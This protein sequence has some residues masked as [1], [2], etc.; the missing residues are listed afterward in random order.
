MR[1]FIAIQLVIILIIIGLLPIHA[2][3]ET[4]NRLEMNVE[5]GFNGKAKQNSGF[6]VS[7]TITN[8][9]E[10]F[11][12]DLVVTVP[13][14]YQSI[15]NIVMPIDIATGSTKEINFSIPSFVMESY[16]GA[17]NQRM[18]FFHL[19]EG[20]WKKGKKVK[21]DSS[22]KLQPRYFADNQSVI[23]IVS[24]N[25]DALN[26]L[27][28][29]S[30]SGTNK[31]VISLKNKNIPDEALGLQAIDMLVVND[32][33]FSSLPEKKQLAVKEWVAQ[34]G[35]LITGSTPGL[36]KKMGL[37]ADILPLEVSGSKQVSKIELLEQLGEEALPNEQFKLAI[38]TLKKETRV[39]F[40][41]GD[42][43]LVSALEYGKGKVTQMS[44]DIT[45]KL[46][47]DW[48]GN[49]RAWN[50]L[51]SNTFI[52]DRSDIDSKHQKMSATQELSYIS[53]MFQSFSKIPFSI[54]AI[55]FLVYLIILAPFV[56][57]VLKR[58]DKR[59]WIWL[60]IPVIA[61]L[62][63]VALYVVGAKDRLGD[64][65]SNTNAIVSLDGL[66]GGTGLGS[67]AFLSKDAG[68]YKLSL[69]STYE[70]FPT[71]RGY[72]MSI[73]SNTI[74]EKIPTIEKTNQETTV[75][76]PNVE[77][78]TP[79]SVG[80]IMPKNNFGK[81]ETNLEF[82]DG[83]VQGTVQN[84]TSFDFDEMILVSGRQHI[85][86]GELKSGESLKIE[87]KVGISSIFEPI[88][89]NTIF[90]M[91][92]P[93]HGIRF[94]REQE[95]KQRLMQMTF[96]T[97]A[98]NIS[99]PAI[100]GFSR[101]SIVDFSVNE[102]KHDNNSYN[103]LLQ[104]VKIKISSDVKGDISVSLSQPQIHPTEGQI[105]FNGIIR[106]ESF[107]DVS[108]GK[109][110]LVYEIPE[111]LIEKKYK[112][113][114]LAFRIQGQHGNTAVYEV[115]NNLTSS[116]EQI[117]MDRINYKVEIEP[118]DKFLTENG[119]IRLR[120]ITTLNNGPIAVPSA[121]IKGVVNP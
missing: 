44:F 93:Q 2:S 112:V 108:P 103:L 78:W 57:F 90:N 68:D 104:Q 107:I 96:W 48:K 36:S 51:L 67:I 58:Y 101:D 83:N 114:E 30:F 74:F 28:L 113:K 33:V 3:A 82:K 21:I 35:Q 45:N 70:P 18:Q 73:D 8:Q 22:L 32:F 79:R 102:N 116:F 43:P 72:G 12:G 81:I 1:L 53:T 27:K 37:L 38:G 85:K 7:I 20:G 4:K 69:D 19:Y 23:G 25:P 6:P 111:A 60:V 14:D 77:Y 86:I 66:G 47:T 26:F 106:G 105:H 115:F 34:G 63:S 64:I 62:S 29:T 16:Q 54:L 46:L 31:E 88:T 76:F 121:I 59:E 49:T 71:N 61:L 50:A 80:I 9:K 87:S 100:L 17:P 110:E 109:Y 94:D 118:F 13:R 119:Q 117:S 52:V 89:E 95:L 65:Q 56:Y 75:H 42:L 40:Y 91:F 97:G 99:Q 98:I 55:S 11:S 120:V 10:D 24:D 84:L 15:G 39:V 5:V 92:T 41:E